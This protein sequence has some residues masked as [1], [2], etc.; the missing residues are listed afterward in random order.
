MNELVRIDS[1][2]AVPA[3][4]GLDLVGAIMATL[5]A[6][7]AKTYMGDYRDFA[8]FLGGA[9]PREAIEGFLSLGP[10]E[11]NRVVLEYRVH[12]A[13]R[14]LAP[15]TIARRLVA[16]RSACKAARR[17]GRIGWGL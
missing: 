12:M 14:K 11:A 15:G 6:R 3:P 16:L 9:D 17:V 8:R 13:D 4:L 2:H 7:T 5:N 1:G 10:G